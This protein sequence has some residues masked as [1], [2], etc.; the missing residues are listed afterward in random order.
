MSGEALETRLRELAW[1]VEH[2]EAAVRGIQ[3]RRAMAEQLA[4]LSELRQK[5]DEIDQRLRESSQKAEDST[6]EARST[7]R[8]SAARRPAG[9][10]ARFCGSSVLLTT[11]GKRN[12][13]AVRAGFPACGG[14]QVTEWKGRSKAAQELGVSPQALGLWS[15]EEWFPADALRRAPNGRNQYNVTRIRDAAD[16]AGKKG[17]PVSGRMLNLNESI[18]AATS[19][20]R[21]NFRPTGWSDRSRKPGAT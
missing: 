5:R 4:A 13:A 7:R 17:S 11:S 1:S 8:R 6:A 16:A 18:E 21:K 2:L 19:S 14:S 9:S 10:P 3:E 12:V 20:T 15:G